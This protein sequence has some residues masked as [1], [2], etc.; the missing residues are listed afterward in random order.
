[1]RSIWGR[2]WILRRGFERSGLSPVSVAAQT[3]TVNGGTG[4]DGQT[5]VKFIEQIELGGA[6]EL[7]HGDVSFAG[8][9]TGVLGGLYAGSISVAGCLAGFRVTPSGSGS[10]IQATRQRIG[11]WASGGNDRRASISHDD[12]HLFDGG[13]PVGRDLSLVRRIRQAVDGEGRRF[14]L[15]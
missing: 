13:V 1:M 14:R 11:D 8:P 7:Q 10:T 9:S 3:L 5:S 15:T 2:G 6:L 4:Q 12:I